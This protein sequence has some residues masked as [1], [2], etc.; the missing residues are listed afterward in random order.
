M[1][2]P[3][4]PAAPPPPAPP[5]SPAAAPADGAAGAAEELFLR[6]R[7]PVGN[8]RQQLVALRRV[9]GAA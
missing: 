6:T 5:A 2:P 8:F 3:A 4:P 7:F 1:P 9:A